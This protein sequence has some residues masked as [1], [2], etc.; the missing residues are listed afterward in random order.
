MQNNDIRKEIEPKVYGLL[1]E[2][3]DTVFLSLQ[4]AYSLEEAFVLAKLEYEKQNP[5]RTGPLN[6]LMGAKIGLFSIKTIKELTQPSELDKIIKKLPRILN[7]VP[8]PDAENIIRTFTGPTYTLGNN[9]KSS[10]KLSLTE[11]EK[12]SLMRKIIKG[13]D[14]KMFKKNKGVFNSEEIKYL[15]EKLKLDK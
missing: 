5:Q 11:K 13:K 10:S 8:N 2:S 7:P 3:M 4:H 14:I 1:L 9:K 12:N 6:P 15:G